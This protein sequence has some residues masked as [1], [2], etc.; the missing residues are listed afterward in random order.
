MKMTY[1]KPTVWEL[2]FVADPLMVNSPFKEA[3]TSEDISVNPD[4][5]VNTGLSRRFDVWGGEE[6]DF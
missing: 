1:Q 5:E 6:E 4:Q 2:P 3:E